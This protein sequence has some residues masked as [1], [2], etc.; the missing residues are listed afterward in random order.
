[1]A[2]YSLPSESTGFCWKS[3]T[4]SAI[5]S[6]RLNEGAR[7]VFSEQL[8]RPKTELR[9]E[10]SVQ[11]L[12]TNVE[13]GDQTRRCDGPCGRMRSVKELRVYGR[14]EH[15][16]CPFCTINAPMIENVDGSMGCCNPECFAADLA[17]LCPD[18]ILRR[19]YFQMIIN[20]HKLDE[21]IATYRGSRNMKRLERAMESLSASQISLASKSTGGKRGL[22]ELVGIKVLILE[23]GPMGTISRRCSINEIG[24]KETLRDTLQWI[25]GD[26]LHMSRIFISYGENIEES[27][28]EEIDLKKYGNKKISGFPSTNSHISLVVDCT[29]LIQG[30][31]N[32]QYT[33][34]HPDHHTNS[35]TDEA[36][37]FTK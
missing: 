30:N 12:E 16:I 18:P 36:V 22:E 25:V 3:S 26:G 8:V 29:N 34:T 37:P 27:K 2:S 7:P 5:S 23:K 31:K 15:A 6:E 19:K 13:V 21:I 20:K 10:E 4:K 35:L 9:Q 1:M 11:S 24:S 32:S 14:C 28:L 33:D 17:V